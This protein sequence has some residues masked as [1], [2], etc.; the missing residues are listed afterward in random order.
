MT[1]PVG[2]PESAGWVIHQLRQLFKNAGIINTF[3][4]CAGLALLTTQYYSKI[5]TPDLKK[6]VVDLNSGSLVFQK[7]LLHLRVQ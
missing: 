4:R 2:Q 5:G 6:F 7:V 3:Y 1:Q